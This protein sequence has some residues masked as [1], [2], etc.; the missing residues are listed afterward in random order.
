MDEQA[1]D[2]LKGMVKDSSEKIDRLSISLAVIET[3]V[4]VYS[5]LIGGG[6]GLAVSLATKFFL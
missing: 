6:I 1:F 2:L 5:G 3:K 4:K